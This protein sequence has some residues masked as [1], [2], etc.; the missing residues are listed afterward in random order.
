MRQ[1]FFLEGQE[2]NPWDVVRRILARFRHHDR[3]YLAYL[4]AHPTASD[5]AVVRLK[6]VEPLL[7]AL[8]YNPQTDLDPEHRVKEGA[9]DVLVRANDLP[10]ML[11]ELKRTQ[12]TNL[13]RY[14]DQL[15]RYLPAVG[16]RY[17]ILTNGREIRIYTWAGDRLHWVHSFSLLA[18]APNAPRPPTED[19]RLALLVFFDLLHKEAF[20]DVE[21]FKQEIAEATEPRLFLSPDNPQNEALL[22]EGLK[23]EIRRLHRLV[24]LRFRSHQ[25]L[26][27]AFQAEEARRR[28]EVEAERAK[29]W[30]WLEKFEGQTRVT[31]NRPA[32]ERYLEDFTEHWTVIEEPAFVR[33]FLRR[34]GLD[35]YVQGANH[36]N[37][38]NRLRSFYR[39]FVDHARWYA[40]QSVK[41]RS[42]RMIVENFAQWRDETGPMAEDYE[43]EFCLQT[44]Y[45]FITRV[46]LIRICEDKG[47]ITQKISDG[48]YGDYL[49][50]SRQFFTYLAD[51]NRTLLDLAYKD[52]G[53][54]Y[55]HFF[56]QDIFDWYVWEEEAIVRLFHLLNRFDF[57]QV[58][59][60]LIGHIYEQY[61][62][63][64]ERKRKGQFY[65]PSQVVN[66]VLD[67]VGYRGEATIG[68]R[69]L[70]PACGSGRF[71]VEAARRLI[72]ALRQK[73]P[74]LE[75]KTLVNEY[76][77]DSLFGLDVNRFACFLAEV[78]LLVQVLDLVREGD[79]FTVERFHIYATNT[80]LPR[81]QEIRPLVGPG[82]GL[83]YETEVAELIKRREYNPAL[84]LDF[85]RGFDW[86]V[87]N[88]PYVRADHPSVASLREQIQASGRYKTIHKKWDLYIPFIEFALD[89]LAEGGRHSFIVSD[90]YQTEAYA[91]PSRQ[92]LLEETTIESL[93][94][95]P[96]I[97]FFAEAQ[98][99]NL[100]YAVRQ[101]APPK[102]HR[103]QRFK[104][105][106]ARLRKTDIKLLPALSQRRWGERIFRPE[107]K[108]EEE[109][110]FAEYPT[111]GDLCYISYGLAPVSH[112]DL[113][114]RD[115]A[116]KRRKLFVTEDLLAD[117]PDPKHPKK[118][119][120]GKDL[121]RFQVLRIRWLEWGTDRVPGQLRRKKFP[122]LFENEKLL[123][124]RR[125]HRGSL[126]A[127]YDAQG[128]MYCD[129]TVIC[130]VPAHRLL[131]V[132]NRTLDRR[133]VREALARAA[134]HSPDYDLKYLVALLNCRWLSRHIF[135]TIAKGRVDFYPDNLRQYPIAPANADTQ[136][137]IAQVV[138]EITTAR[139][140]LHRWRERGHRIG[141][142]GIVLNPRPFLDLWNIPYGD[143]FVAGSF[144]SWHIGGHPTM[145]EIEGQRLILRKQPFSYIESEVPDVLRY[146]RLYLEANRDELRRHPVARLPHQILLPRSPGEVVRFLDRLEKE[147]EVVMLR[148]MQ[149]VQHEA[150]LEEQIFDLYG[151]DE[152]WRE[153][154][155]G[156][157]YRFE[158]IPPQVAFVSILDRPNDSPMRRVAFPRRGVWYYRTPRPLPQAVLVWMH[159]GRTA[160]TQ[161]QI[162]IEHAREEE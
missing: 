154:L 122:E 26:Y 123:V 22:I 129:A 23:R 8:G 106:D 75:P 135:Q 82:N 93:T 65:T 152:G 105:V 63:E 120:Q 32:L 53:H 76:V 133:A 94:F 21:R 66:Y 60:D 162:P 108:G 100:I 142:E 111:L 125:P 96:G 35:R 68:R 112:E 131:G 17:G 144:V 119:V 113:D 19:E 114:P 91:H 86:I 61:V 132:H 155:G 46:L 20:L 73:Y 146:L 2:T 121:D 130:A 83:A 90:A 87:G 141:E 54:I 62:D 102:G 57:S 45:I 97:K 145:L 3:T 77:R 147:R 51:A 50:F 101:G 34:S 42:S 64:L 98:V 59:A 150:W 137:Q 104:V 18:F 48:G 49:Q 84:R 39:V 157:S 79:H 9:I 136:A 33:A 153:K 159:D 81:A 30:A 99:H 88:P 15:A 6:I 7:E 109:L 115:E 71:L 107:F 80:L 151:V 56:S 27:R 36:V 1:G 44:V 13:T 110:D 161:W 118:F 92:R 10:V 117:T 28:A 140:D 43:V 41:L 128:E 95:A 74:D 78:N 89:L 156:R 55:G 70:D 25:A 5:E 149:V 38:Q 24:L 4:D 143:L 127:Y 134:R 31:L 12:E 58:S 139:E 37:L 16:A 116:G 29:L 47:L 52:T 138:D 148:W 40:R 69:L 124:A 72:K 14:E 85:R 67:Q 11:W 126:K 160:T 158:G 103:V